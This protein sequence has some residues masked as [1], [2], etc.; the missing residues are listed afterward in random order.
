LAR[1]PR[2]LIFEI[3]W[4]GKTPGKRVAGIRAIKDT[5]RALNVFEVIGRNLMRAVDALPTFY[6][7]GIL[8]VLIS[9]KNQRL[10]DL[11]A[12]SIVVHDK[13][14][15]PVGLDSSRP[16]ATVPNALTELNRISSEELVL[17]ET[18]LQR[19]DTFDFATRDATAY[20]I[21]SRITA[22][23]GIQRDSNQSLEEFLESIAKQLRDSATL[24]P[25]D[26]KE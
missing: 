15:E 3:I 8:T 2:F 6:L 1:I 5:G 16:N 11:L 13:A 14:P 18:F 24:R 26:H 4:K 10:G 19:R 21:A 7:V 17:I 12:G 25:L 23:T 22:K 20:K 9:R